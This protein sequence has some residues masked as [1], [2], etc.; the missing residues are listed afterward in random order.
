MKDKK[1]LVTG[2]TGYI[3][4]RLVPRLLDLG[5]QVRVLV[6]DRAR[7]QGRDWLERVEVFQGDVLKPETLDVVMDRVSAA[8]YLVHSMGANGDFHERDLV[9]ARNF[10][11]AAKTAGIEQIVYLRLG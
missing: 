4:G 1:I 5:Y 3:G 10:G 8:Y 6:R 11:Q 9:A 7:L 2:P